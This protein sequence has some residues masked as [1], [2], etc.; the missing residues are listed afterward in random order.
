M[1]GEIKMAY[2][3]QDCGNTEYFRAMLTKKETCD[4]TFDGDVMVGWDDHGFGDVDIEDPHECKECGSTNIK[5]VLKE[6]G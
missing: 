5:K 1:K 2:K 4:V 6:V 3:C